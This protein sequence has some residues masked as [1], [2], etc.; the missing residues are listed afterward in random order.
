VGLDWN[1]RAS[2]VCERPGSAQE[3]NQE[4]SFL[5]ERSHA[6][7]ARCR[8][9]RG[10]AIIFI[11]MLALAILPSAAW[12]HRLEGDAQAKKVQ[13]VKIESWFDL[14]GVPSGARLQVFRKSDGQLLLER[15]LDEN[16]RLTFFADWEPLHVVISAG[17]GHQ[18]EIDIQPEAD[19]TS[20]L[21]AADRSSRIGI[22]DI[23]IGVGFLLAFAAF[24]L[25]VRNHRRIGASRVA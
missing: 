24:V 15:S 21:P 10:H 1:S 9:G 12:A 8:F 16:G 5:P 22:K 18:K 20:P 13:K 14:G 2:V 11:P 17:D 7:L 4:L 25:S 23:L 6:P 19:V 3:T